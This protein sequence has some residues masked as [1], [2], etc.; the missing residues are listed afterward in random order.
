M[1]LSAKARAAFYR[2]MA[3]ATQD[4]ADRCEDLDF[5]RAYVELAARWL[6]LAAEAEAEAEADS[7]TDPR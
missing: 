2:D 5:L 3:R 4:L 7:S 6:R 1:E